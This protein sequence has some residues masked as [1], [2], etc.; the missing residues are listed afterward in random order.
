MT[1]LGYRLVVNAPDQ[2]IGKIDLLEDVVVRDTPK[3]ALT[4]LQSLIDKSNIRWKSGDALN[5]IDYALTHRGRTVYDFEEEEDI[6]DFVGDFYMGE[7]NYAN[8]LLLHA[9]AIY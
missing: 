5:L 8:I 1:E 9:V 3:K 2:F 4:V 7:G 6:W